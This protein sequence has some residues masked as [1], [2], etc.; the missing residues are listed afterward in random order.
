[1]AIVKIFNIA[2][3]KLN[4]II[5][6]PLDD[7]EDGW[8]G[9][10]FT[11]YLRDEYFDENTTLSNI[12][13]RKYNIW[14]LPIVPLLIEGGSN[15][16]MQ[17]FE[18]PVFDPDLNCQIFVKT[19]TGKT[20][21]IDANLQMIT[22]HFK[23]KIQDKEGIPPDVQR[24]IFGGCQFEDDKRLND[25]FHPKTNEHLNVQKESTFHLVL[26]L[27]GGGGGP[28]IPF[29]NLAN[30]SA[31]ESL[32]VSDTGPK[33]LTIRQGLNL[34]GLCENP[35]CEAHNLEVI[36]PKSFGAHTLSP[37]MTCPICHEK[38]KSTTCGFFRCN[39]MIEGTQEDGTFYNSGQKTAD[40]SDY[41]RFNEVDNQANWLKLVIN[42]EYIPKYHECSICM[43]RSECDHV[44]CTEM[45]E[46]FVM[47]EI[48]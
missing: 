46:S 8:T 7:V 6:V 42:T 47:L 29:A 27:R 22:Y 21:T 33:R 32:A 10:N 36:Q 5:R 17:I 13:Y 20:I 35:K 9:D 15:L 40:G 34:H 45:M 23:L 11:K 25:H 4:R 41:L 18:E 37:T 43:Q 16:S 12:K 44:E 14:R 48:N 26:R 31:S 19:L 28:P 3:N 30:E 39:Y 38:S 2:D 24:L 1:M